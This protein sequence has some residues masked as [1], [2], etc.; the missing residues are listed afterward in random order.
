VYVRSLVWL[1][2]DPGCESGS[3]GR[4]CR[5]ALGAGPRWPLA[6]RLRNSE[7]PRAARPSV[8]PRA[9]SA[10]SKYSFAGAHP[11]ATDPGKPGNARSKLGIPMCAWDHPGTPE[12]SP[13][14]PGIPKSTWARLGIPK[15]TRL[16][17]NI[18]GSTSVRLKI[19]EHS[20]IYPGT[21]LKVY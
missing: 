1:G 14:C 5:T 15:C 16:Y 7:A 11:P 12:Y 4:S 20:R 18:R 9:P 2:D 6:H 17:M 3:R 13:A 21:L 19:P 8:C 10:L